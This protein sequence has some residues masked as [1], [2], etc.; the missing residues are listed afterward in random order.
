MPIGR[1]NAALYIACLA[2]VA[3]IGQESSPTMIKG[4]GP[5]AS[6]T[7]QLKQHHVELSREGLLKAL[8]NPDGRVRDLAA[9]RLAEEKDTSAVP[10]IEEALARE[11]LPET[12]I[13]IAFSLMQFGQ[14]KGVT[15]LTAACKDSALPGYL[16]ARAIL[17]MLPLGNRTCFKAALDLLHTDPDSRSQ[18]LSLL[19][20]YRSPSN[21]ESE[22]ILDATTSCLT[23]ESGAVRIQASF[24]LSTLANPSA[25]PYLQSA[26]AAERDDTVRAQMQ[27]SLKLLQENQRR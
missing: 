14:Q 18:V 13:N 5:P 24:T 4:G 8:R 3:A 10:A 22:E 16:R 6:L 19:P 17:Y 1:T 26:I 11:K 20:Q 21:E 7:E 12:R 27:D 25:I 15:E 23:D 9:A 2:A